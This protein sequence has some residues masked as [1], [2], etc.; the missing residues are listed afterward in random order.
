MKKFIP[1]LFLVLILPLTQ[2]SKG[3]SNGLNTSK[4]GSLSRFAIQGNRMYAIDLNF[5]KVFDLSNID[6]PVE[7]NKVELDYGLETI[8]TTDNFLYVGARDGIYVCD[9]S[10]EDLPIYQAKISHSFSCDPVVVQGNY[11]YSTLRVTES[12]C[13]DFN[14]FSELV[15]YNISDKSNVFV[16][17]EIN[18]DEPYGLG[19]LNDKLFVCEG[20]GSLQVYDIS[21]P[22]YPEL[23]NSFA[24]DNPRDVIVEENRIILSTSTD[25][26]LLSYDAEGNIQ[27]ISSFEK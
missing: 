17:T 5:V 14:S 13:G 26:K 15:V 25:L 18:M 9:I 23:I 19:A 6:N 27:L 22:N 1:F 24:V 8:F 12:G 7:V 4:S 16:E 21:T 2:C 20:S 3:D 11:A 10:N